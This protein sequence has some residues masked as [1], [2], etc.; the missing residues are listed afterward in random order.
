MSSEVSIELISKII[1]PHG[2]W[3][4]LAISWKLSSGSGPSNLIP[5]VGLEFSQHSGWVLRRSALEANLP[6][7]RK[8]RLLGQLTPLPGARTALPALC[9]IGQSRLRLKRV[10]K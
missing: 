4:V 8:Y 9:S 3:L 5:S 7:N 1:L 6:R 10:E 2:W